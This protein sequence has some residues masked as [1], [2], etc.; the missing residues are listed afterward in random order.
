MAL[1][2]QE[3]SWTPW[4]IRYEPAFRQRY[5]APLGLPPSEEIARSTSWG[6]CQVM[7][8]LAREHGFT[9]KFLSELCDPAMG[10]EYGC[11]VLDTKLMHNS[12]NM[13]SALLS[14]NGGSA[15][16]YPSEVLAKANY[17]KN[18]NAGSA[19]N[20]EGKS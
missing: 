2:E 13:V 6:L 14:Y 10:I 12:G 15:P 16:G 5:V 11:R 20:P 17:Y 19:A 7:G 3:S 4:A 9:G 1:C 8:Q 18:S